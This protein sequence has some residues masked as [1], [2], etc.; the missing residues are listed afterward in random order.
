MPKPYPREFREDV[1]QG[2]RNRGPG[3]TLAQVAGDLGVHPKTLQKW[4]R[5]ADG[6]DGAKPG[7]P[8]DAAAELRELK[9]RN[10]LLD[11]E[12]EVFRR[13]AATAHEPRRNIPSRR[14]HIFRGHRSQSDNDEY[15]PVSVP[16]QA[17]NP[18]NCAQRVRT[19]PFV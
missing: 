13:A 17:R 1:V 8:S 7:V 11:Q 12:N 6:E 19:E 4:L 18:E 5:A 16:R 10:R 14:Y 9:R 15:L 3:V 2:A